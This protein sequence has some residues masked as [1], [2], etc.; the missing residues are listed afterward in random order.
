MFP[1]DIPPAHGGKHH[2]PQPLC[3]SWSGP[4]TELQSPEQWDSQVSISDGSEVDPKAI[5]FLWP[6][7]HNSVHC[8]HNRSLF[9]WPTSV[10]T[11]GGPLIPPENAQP[12]SNLEQ[13]FIRR[14]CFVSF[15]NI[16]CSVT[17]CLNEEIS[18][19]GFWRPGE[20]FS[21]AL[22]FTHRLYF[23]PCLTE[24]TQARNEN[25]CSYL[26]WWIKR[27]LA[28]VPTEATKR[29]HRGNMDQTSEQNFVRTKPYEH[30]VI[31][32]YVKTT[33]QYTV[34]SASSLIANL[35]I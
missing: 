1:V 13:A 6:F 11:S 10:R 4:P 7:P 23:S 31:K 26:C 24:N 33:V 20:K 35:E 16:T 14:V 2:F 12:L 5:T 29:C 21:K 3:L 19:S 8:S 17:P 9:L 32:T 27:S 15:G 18:S 28:I 34:K 25:V 30:V 22:G